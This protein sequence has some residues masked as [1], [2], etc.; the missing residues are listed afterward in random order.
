[1]K[2]KGIQA[3]SVLNG[4][5]PPPLP[6]HVLGLKHFVLLY[7]YFFSIF[8]GRDQLDQLFSFFSNLKSTDCLKFEKL[9]VQQLILKLRIFWPIQTSDVYLLCVFP[10]K[11]TDWL[12]N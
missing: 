8:S 1:M 7:A 9:R 2:I 10:K 4:Q 5:N 12:K 11:L 6:S 3:I